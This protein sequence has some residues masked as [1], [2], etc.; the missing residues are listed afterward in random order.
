MKNRFA[1][2]ALM[3]SL[4]GLFSQPALALPANPVLVS[5][6]AS[7]SSS[8]DT[9]D[10][11][12]ESDQLNWS[13]FSVALGQ[14]VNFIQSSSSP[15]ADNRLLGGSVLEV[16]GVLRS[17]RP[18]ILHA[19]N[20]YIAP[21]GVIDAPGLSLFG[22]QSV[23]MAGLVQGAGPLNITAP[24]I[25]VKGPLVSDGVLVQADDYHGSGSLTL[26][27]NGGSFSAVEVTMVN[28]PVYSGVFEVNQPSFAASV[29][30]PSEWMMFV[31]GLMT[32]V[33]VARRR[34]AG[35]RI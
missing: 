1:G 33:G 25:F 29:P 17:N 15:G 27:S 2:V 16:F 26:G 22:A 9:L 12:A 5:G 10:I 28:F 4:F 13:S 14:T 8:G 18:L 23:N 19:D 3:V 20:I 31:A 30:E 32:I 24:S 35:W 7:F 11:V 34:S 6:N 21:G